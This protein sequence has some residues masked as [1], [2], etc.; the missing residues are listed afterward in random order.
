[1]LPHD[2]PTAAQ[3]PPVQHPLAQAPAQQGCPSAPQ[4]TQVPFWQIDP[5]AVQ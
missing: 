2:A 3:V 1:L 4:A 5:A